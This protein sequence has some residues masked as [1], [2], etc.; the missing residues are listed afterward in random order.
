MT[1]RNAP[2]ERKAVRDRGGGGTLDMTIWLLT[3]E[4]F[5]PEPIR[6]TRPAVG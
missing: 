5:L 2:S 1:P 4:A 3:R 6:I